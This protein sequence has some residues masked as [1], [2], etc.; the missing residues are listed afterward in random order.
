VGALG[1]ASRVLALEIVNSVD[2]TSSE[3]LR[4]AAKS[5]I[6]GRVII[7]ERQTGGRGRRGRSWTSIAGGSLVFSIG[8][9]FAQGA[10]ELTALSLAVGLA[11]ADALERDGFGGVGLKWPNDLVHR[12]CKLGGVLVE[13]SGPARGASLAVIGVGIN[14]RLPPAIRRTI[15]Q[16]VTDLASIASTRRID[17]NSLLGRLLAEQVRMLERYAVS[18]FAP[19]HAAWERRHALHGRTVQVHRPDGGA[20][21]G[22]VAGVDADGALRLSTAGRTERFLSGEVSLRRP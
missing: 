9:R 21:Y 8:W 19:M 15:D 18:G 7:A 11:L 12:Q 3:L 1:F 20:V 14:V 16:P 13:L 6:H 17:R 2:S 5:D 4:Q 22:T 10:G